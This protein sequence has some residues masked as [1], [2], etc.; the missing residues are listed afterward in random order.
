MNITKQQLLKGAGL[1]IIGLLS[2][3]LLFGGSSGQNIPEN[4]DHERTEVDGEE[5]WTCS[6]HPSVREDGPGQCPICGMDLIPATS[7][8]ADDDDYSMVMT[9]AAVQLANIQT[10]PV[11]REIPTR[12]ITLPGRVEVDERRI[13]Y[14]TTHFEGRIRDV[15][16][17]FT[18]APIQK[19]DV[20]ATVYSPDI[21]SAQ[22]ELLEAVRVKDRNPGLY[23]SA[24][25]KF[26]LW[27]FTDEQIRQI[28]ERGEVQTDM[29]ILSPVDG[30]VMKRNVLSEQH[31]MEGT[32]IYEVANL[33]K[34]WVTFDAYE[35]DLNWLSENDTVHFTTRSNPGQTY[36][37]TI[38]Y[39]DPTFNPQKRTIRIRAVVD[40]SDRNLRPD[41][42]VNGTLQANMQ[43]EKL[44]I[45]ATSV[46]W[47]GPRSL[48]YIQDTTADTPR[49]EV[50]TV[51]LG[52]RTGDYYVIEEGINEG[53]Q[54]V[55]HGNFRIDS[56]FQLADRFSMMNREPGSGAVPGHQHGDM[57]QGEMDEMEEQQVEPEQDHGQS[58]D[59]PAE[60]RTKLT[61]AVEAYIRG[62]DAFVNSD[63]Q[64]AA[65]EFQSFTE[66]LEAIGEH[67]LTGSGHEEWMNGYSDLRSPA[68][69]ITRTNSIEQARTAFRNLSDQLIQAVQKFGIDGAVY[70]Q[71]CPMAF[72][73]EGANWLSNS[74]QIQNPYLSETMPGC[75]EIIES[76]D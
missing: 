27:E 4:H 51:E 8:A 63:L 43:D 12:E 75:G 35:E 47:T 62:K 25:R 9:E 34:L 22:R 21:V 58:H 76:L 46:L 36:E 18:G 39:I 33:E 42:L 48:V 71:Y 29:E 41:M 30:F 16:I 57:D 66:K 28:V 31:V 52:P 24:V 54:V 72:D 45:P 14:V 1:V 37:A 7:E 70:Q 32:I 5:V 53:D 61:E 65:A 20:M 3:W 15:K 10:S 6:M 67:G 50:K 69:E 38:S 11:I 74:E 55:T 73:N 26:K 56:E 68:M 23:E 2:G 64:T 59:V 17:D 44:L 40:N 19:G 13:S 49:F 60:F